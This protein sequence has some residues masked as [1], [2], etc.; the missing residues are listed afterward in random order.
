MNHA[1]HLG[2]SLMACAVIAQSAF[3]ADLQLSHQLTGRWAVGIEKGGTQMLDLAWQPEA[4]WRFDDG[5]RLTGIARLRFQPETGL[6]PSDMERDSYTAASRPALIGNNTELVLR[7]LYYEQ[8]AGDWYATLGKQQVVWG[9]ADG[10]K[11][12]DVVNPQSFREFILEDFDQS[13]IPLWTV[14]VERPLNDWMGGDWTLQLLWLPDQTYHALPEQDATYAFSSPRLAPQAPPA[15][16]ARLNKPEQPGSILADSDAGLRLTSF[17]GGWDISLNYLYQYHNQPALHQRFIPGPTPVVEITPEYHRTHVLGGSFSRAFGSWVIR[18]ELGYFTDRFFL[19]KDVADSDGVSN[20]SELSYVLGLDWS[21]I[22]DT[23]IS[24][25]LFQSWLP[26]HKGGFTR[27]ELDTS[28]TFL[29][30]REFLNDTLTTEVLWIA[31]TNDGDGLVRP[32]VS[33]DLEDNISI[34]A[35]LDIFYGDRDG[36]FGQ[37]KDKDRFLLGV[38]LGF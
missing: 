25:Q 13:R 34:W 6:R 26:D 7:E 19:T 2:C 5:G 36:L 15:V 14:N 11:V 28:V 29:V 16:T 18:G 30:R 35:G 9:K 10:L 20:S 12:L 22:D 33:Y 4:Q 38:E 27:P 8:T 17:I 23:F 3:A 37:F 32:K 1:M 31:N 21:G 24:V